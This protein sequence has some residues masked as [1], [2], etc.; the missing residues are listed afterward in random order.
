MLLCL[1]RASASFSF[2]DVNTKDNLRIN[3]IDV[4]INV[5][6]NLLSVASRLV[7][8]RAYIGAV[9]TFT[10][11]VGGNRLNITKDDINSFKMYGQAG[12]GVD[13]AFFFLETGVNY[14]F[15]DVLKEINSN[16]T[17]VFVNLGFRF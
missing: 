2:T 3:S 12:L 17:Q 14:G 15:T 6:I 1:K 9:P 10:T 7:G 16:H 5:G 4:P 11:K 8:L 13:I